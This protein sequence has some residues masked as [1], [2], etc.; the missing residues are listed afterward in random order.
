MNNRADSRLM[1]IRIDALSGRDAY[2]LMS[3]IIVPRPIAWVSTISLAGINNLA[4]FSFFQGVTSRPPTLLFVPVNDR[5]GRKK[6]TILNI[7][8]VPEFVVNIAD[9]SMATLVDKTA[10]SLPSTESEFNEFRIETEP[11]SLIRPPRVKEAPISM[12]CTLDQIVKIGSG[13]YGAN[14]VFGKIQIIHF[15]QRLINEEGMIDWK[16]FQPL[17]RIGDHYGSVIEIAS[18]I[19]HP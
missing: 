5:E 11:S 14:V 4:P 1:E 13:P 6:D 3:Q 8:S 7:E 19:E 17:A 9:P 15:N 10:T 2:Q 12:E 18:L 16:S